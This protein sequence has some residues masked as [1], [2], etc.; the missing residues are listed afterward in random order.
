MSTSENHSFRGLAVN[1]LDTT[2]GH[3]GK[4]YTEYAF[5]SVKVKPRPHDDRKMR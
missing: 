4:I 5:L 1:D 3:H 2:N